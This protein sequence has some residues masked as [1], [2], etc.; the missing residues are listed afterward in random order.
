M[1]WDT[2]TPIVGGGTVTPGAPA[3][4]VN[5]STVP[6]YFSQSAD[7]PP[8]YRW[9]GV[10]GWTSG[11]YRTAG[12]VLTY[13]DQAIAA[14][15]GDYDGIYYVLALGV[16]G[17]IYRGVEVSSDV[18]VGCAVYG[19]AAQSIPN[20]AATVLTFDLERVDPF[21]MHSPST[22][23]SRVTVPEPGWYSVAGHVTFAFHATGYRRAQLSLNGVSALAYQQVPAVT[24]A[25]HN[26]RLSVNDVVYMNAGDYIELSVFQLSGGALDVTAAPMASPELR[27]VK[28][29]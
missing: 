8:R 25:G 23:P 1:I 27:V 18:A 10:V 29:G 28:V 20:N 6:A 9:L 11:T 17:T 12:Q 26:T 3:V 22:N 13:A 16:S 14:P 7:A 19:S 21:G 2:G 5:L 24:D 15:G 4:R